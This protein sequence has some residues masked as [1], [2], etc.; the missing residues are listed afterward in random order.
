MHPAFSIIFFTSAAGAGYGLLALLGLL[1]PF[2][3]LPASPLFSLA[4]LALAL[5]LV[6]AGLLS[7][8]AH[9]GRPERAWRA[10]SQWRSSW[11]SREG[12]AAVATFLPAGVFAIAWFFLGGGVA[13]VAGWI[14]A[15][16]AAVTV[17]C[18]AMIYA[19]LKPI[20]QWA[21]PWVPRTYLALSLMTGALLLNA[22]LGVAGQ[23]AGWSS[24]LALASVALAW[25]AKEGHWRHC[26]TARPISTAETATGLGHIGRVRL[27][28]AP[29]SEDNYLLKEMGFR[30]GRRHAIRLRL[31]T[32]LA[33][34]A[35]PAALSLG[36]LFAGPGAL[37]GTL[38]LLAAAAAAL[39]VIAER[40]LFFAEAKHTVTLFYGAG[41]A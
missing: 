21:N 20:R 25:A 1:A 40:W 28:D 14:T 10:L 32:R 8:L 35:L 17:Y 26:A 19:S 33:A 22:L 15:A 38:A 3:L 27:L 29:H 23:A 34:F 11:L 4:A 37:S 24:L 5:G 30:V 6:V 16:M 9:L 41:E 36:A 7:S 13:G 2:G 39:G 18:T 31:I 12:V